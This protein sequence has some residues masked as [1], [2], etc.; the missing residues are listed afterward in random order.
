MPRYDPTK[1]D[2]ENDGVFKPPPEGD[3]EFIVVEANEQTSKA[4]NEMVNLKLAVE[5]G[6]DKP[7]TTYDRLVFHD[8]CI[9]RIHG[10]CAATGADF[11]RGELTAPDC[12]GRSGRAH[13]KLGDPNKDGKRYMEVTYYCKPQGYSESPR[14]APATTTTS[15]DAG[16]TWTEDPTDAGANDGGDTIP[17]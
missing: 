3:Y 13:L 4:G 8:N 16:P 2:P 9:N 7:M 1:Y 11:S 5:I 14:N 12:I 10:F 17:F 15:A 6:R